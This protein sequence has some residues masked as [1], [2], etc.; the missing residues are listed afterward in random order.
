MALGR[1]GACAVWA[2]MG[3]TVFENDCIDD[4]ADIELR[5]S[6][7]DVADAV[8]VRVAPAEQEDE[9]PP[10]LCFDAV[11][12][13]GE[14]LGGQGGIFYDAAYVAQFTDWEDE[15][16]V[17]IERPNASTLEA[18]VL[19]PPDFRVTAPM[20]DA[21]L[22]RAESQSITWDPP[23]SGEIRIEATPTGGPYG[24][25]V[26]ECWIVFDATGPDTGF[27]LLGPGEFEVAG[28]DETSSCRFNLMLARTRDGAYPDD[29]GAGSI[30]ATR[31]RGVTVTSVP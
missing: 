1:L 22:S 19:A 15:Y 16:T 28:G 23:S 26:G 12:V 20:Y 21:K 8:E 13:N 2:S 9:D 27:H 31:W 17:G 7:T 3:C 11:T 5:I 6:V 14:P 18:S 24:G 4:P 30:A 10:K 25:N 29:L